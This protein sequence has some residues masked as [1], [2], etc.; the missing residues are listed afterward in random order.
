[1]LIV[2]LLDDKEHLG[3]GGL[4]NFFLPGFKDIVKLLKLGFRRR[5]HR[6]LYLYS[7]YY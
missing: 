6:Y 4:W 7:I 2:D 5:L 3:S 1:M